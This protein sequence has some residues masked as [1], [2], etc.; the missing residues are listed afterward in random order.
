MLSQMKYFMTD[1]NN[2]SLYSDKLKFQ[3]SNDKSNSTSWT[4]LHVADENIHEG[5]NYVNFNE[6]GTLPKYR[7]YRMY[8]S[9]S[10]GCLVNEIK[11]TGIETVDNND[12]TYSCNVQV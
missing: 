3:G 9:T 11:F 10:N 4:D 5:W 7:F 2:P 12:A 1:I 8:S 6:T